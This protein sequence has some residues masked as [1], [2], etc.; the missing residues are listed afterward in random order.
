MIVYASKSVVFLELS[1]PGEANYARLQ[2]HDI[3]DSSINGLDY[4]VTTFSTWYRGRSS[5]LLLYLSVIMQNVLRGISRVAFFLTRE[6][7]AKVLITDEYRWLNAIKTITK[8]QVMIV[9]MFSRNFAFFKEKSGAWYR[10][11]GAF[12]VHFGPFWQACWKKEKYGNQLTL[13]TG[14]PE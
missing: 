4:S 1:P 3:V 14:L 8:E 13:L 5:P 12:F 2:A 7:G 9:M 11:L 6:G 10:P